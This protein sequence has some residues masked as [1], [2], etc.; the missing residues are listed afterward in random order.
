M[1]VVWGR[2]IAIREK[3]RERGKIAYTDEDEELSER[4]ER[5]TKKVAAWK[6]I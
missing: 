6:S 1:A 4:R 2:I 3:V 5:E